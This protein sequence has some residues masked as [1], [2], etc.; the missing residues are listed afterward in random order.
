MSYLFCSSAF[1]INNYIL[2]HRYVVFLLLYDKAN[3]PLLRKYAI[4]YTVTVF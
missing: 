2:Y 3:G 1:L 4:S